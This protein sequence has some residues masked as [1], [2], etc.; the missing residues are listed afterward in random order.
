MR[1]LL[2]MSCLA[3][4]VALAV[5]ASAAPR[6]P[7]PVR[8]D[9][10]DVDGVNYVTSVKSQTGGTC[11]THGAMASLESNLLMTGAWAAAGEAGEPNLAEYHLDWW[12]GF[13]QYNNDD[14]EPPT[15]EGVRVHEGGDYLMTAAYLTRGEGAVR[16]ADGQLYSTA[17][18]RSLPTFHFYYARDI[19]FLTAGADLENID[20]IKRQIM[21]L[22]RRRHVPVRRHGVHARRRALPAVVHER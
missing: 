21:T 19:E 20:A 13:N 16:D 2:T 4:A 6:D 1:N 14:I 10:R 3:M 8:F 5:G 12:N 22:R 7:L 9:L 18:P 15:G 17:P 11:W